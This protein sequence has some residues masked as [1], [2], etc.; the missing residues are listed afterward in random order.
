[1]ARYEVWRRGRLWVRVPTSNSAASACIS[2]PLIMRSQYAALRNRV[3]QYSV[4]SQFEISA[5]SA[6]HGL[7]E[8]LLRREVILGHDLEA[9]REHVLGDPRAVPLPQLGYQV[10]AVEP[11]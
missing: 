6:W 5:H 3:R 1:M 9:R 11:H 8:Y 7:H 10:E 4:V 2:G